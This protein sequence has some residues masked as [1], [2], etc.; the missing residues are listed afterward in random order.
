M[1]SKEITTT[2]TLNAWSCKVLG[3]EMRL[4]IEALDELMDD[5]F[6]RKEYQ[7]EHDD[8]SA[9]L[10]RIE[11]AERRIE[12]KAAKRMRDLKYPGPKTER[13]LI[14]EA[15]AAFPAEFGLRAF[16][17]DVFHIELDACY[18]DCGMYMGKPDHK[19]GPM[20]YVYIK[21]YTATGTPDWLSFSKGSPSELRRQMIEIKTNNR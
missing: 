20:L 12:E 14:A 1:S 21:K 4:R 19:P 7:E 3:V 5:E 18:W 13:E 16:P 9:I 2:M 17:G 8:L 6:S 11:A 15:I 10:R